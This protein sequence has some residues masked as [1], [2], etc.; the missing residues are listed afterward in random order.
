MAAKSALELRKAN[1]QLLIKQWGGATNLAKKLKHAGPSYLSQFTSTGRPITEKTARRIEEQLG[2]AIGWLDV[3]HTAEQVP[4]VNQTLVTKVVLVVGATL[5]DAGL[6]VSPTKFADLV[7]L[8]YEEAAKTGQ[9][10]E[11]LVQRL[12]RILK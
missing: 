2:L 5:E 7:A 3:D 1:L 6:T 12:I 4:A 11:A 10:D 9:V 8:V